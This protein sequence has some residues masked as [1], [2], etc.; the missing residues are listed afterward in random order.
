MKRGDPL[1]I[2]NYHTHAINCIEFSGN[3]SLQKDKN[4]L[5]CGSKDEVISVW[6][7]F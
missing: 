7:L 4:L 2:I 5:L 3:E 6:N 1:A